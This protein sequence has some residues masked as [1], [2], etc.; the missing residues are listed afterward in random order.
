MTEERFEEEETRRRFEEEFKKVANDVLNVQMPVGAM[1]AI[2]AN[3]Q[4]ASRHPENT[5]HAVSVARKTLDEIMGSA[6]KDFPMMK[7][8]YEMGWDPRND[9]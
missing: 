9:S 7:M 4:L 1:W 5:G 8:V 6:L 3:V 2:A